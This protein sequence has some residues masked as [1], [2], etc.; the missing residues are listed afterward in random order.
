[1]SEVLTEEEFRRRYNAGE[2]LTEEE[3]QK[4]YSDQSPVSEEEFNR[5]LPGP[6]AVDAIKGVGRALF[7]DPPE[8]VRAAGE[9]TADTVRNLADEY[10]PEGSMLGGGGLR[11]LAKGG[12]GLL[13]MVTANLAPA[14]YVMLGSLGAKKLV[15]T[16]VRKAVASG[17]KQA[18][19]PAARAFGRVANAA[20]RTAS[21]ASIM[22][23]SE[24]VSQGNLAHGTTQVAL[25][26][27]GIKG[28]DDIAR[29][30][31]PPPTVDPLDLKIREAIP[32]QKTS[33]LEQEAF[34]R[35]MHGRQA[36]RWE[37]IRDDA[38]LQGDDYSRELRKAGQDE[39]EKA[40]VVPLRQHLSGD[41]L[42]T[43][44]HRIRYAFPGNSPKSMRGD[45][46]FR[47]WAR[48]ETLQ[49]SELEIFE[50]VFGEGSAK[51]DTAAF[52]KDAINAPRALMASMDMSA[53]LRQNI[54]YS[55]A[56]P[57]TSF[58]AMIRA[59][60]TIPSQ[61][62]YEV[63]S[64]EL[65]QHPMW[66]KAERSGL[67][68]T[69][70]G[71][72]RE[73]QF[74]SSLAEKIPILGPMV[75]A[76]ERFHI[77]F[78]N[79]VRMDVFGDLVK[80][81]GVKTR[82]EFESLADLVNVMTGRGSLGPLEKAA[83]YLNA[84]MFSPRFASARAQ[85][86]GLSDLFRAGES[87]VRSLSPAAEGLVPSKGFYASMPAGVRREAMRDMGKAVAGV[88]TLM[89]LLA[90]HPDVE[91]ETNPRS[92]DFLKGRINN[93]RLDLGAGV[94]QYARL[95]A[96]LGEIGLHVMNAEAGQ[97]TASAKAPRE[98]LS[99]E[100]TNETAREKMVRFLEYKQSPPARILYNML[101]AEEAEGGIGGMAPLVVQDFI[102]GLKE[103]DPKG[104]ALLGA[105]VFFGLGAQQYP[106]PASHEDKA[107][108]QEAQ[109]LGVE[110]RAMR[111]EIR[112]EAAETPVY[113][114]ED[115]SELVDAKLAK[116]T[117]AHER[118]SYAKLV[119]AAVKEGDL[120]RAR[121]LMRKGRREGWR[122]DLSDFMEEAE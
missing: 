9:A 78:L 71:D 1:M 16:M 59:A 18:V 120:P 50:E 41:E 80:K 64:R 117:R 52:F 24:E 44:Q 10:L 37:E 115:Y 28:S 43:V 91:I 4:R 110:T 45:Q 122:F 68:I 47:K 97:R 103:H 86:T 23:G 85:M 15:E 62:S 55:I 102:E 3:F 20:D 111:E 33:G 65:Q 56:H 5:G 79:K 73:E 61:D 42:D 21:A 49:P 112:P 22:S 63:L 12:A 109:R 116:A 89:G 121:K 32:E 40:T 107:K 2:T 34:N 8:P 74:M 92:S 95:Y 118:A 48:G 67:A 98:K 119:A 104:A 46:A 27:L 70:F 14:D 72:V 30:A 87:A 29:A 53:V 76:S 6:G 113:D 83:P 26:T 25:G 57:V 84:T 54:V 17:T 94:V 13:E 106:A 114:S 11:G 96:Q 60:K 77:G 88:S 108:V 100:L 93:T 51:M 66:K 105:A 69:G 101:N 31:A 39:A 36:H 75:K 81:T 99:G 58:K 7:L 19:P 38:S 90:L 82:E 35:Q